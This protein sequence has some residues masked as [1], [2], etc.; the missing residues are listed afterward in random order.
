MCFPDK[1][2]FKNNNTRM[3]YSLLF[4]ATVALG[5]LWLANSHPTQAQ[6]FNPAP[7]SRR[8]MI[9][10]GCIAQLERFESIPG[11]RYLDFSGK[12][13]DPVAFLARNGF[14]AGR[15]GDY[16]IYSL[17][18]P[19]PDNSGD[20]NN[21]ERNFRLDK[22][23]L[24]RQVRTAKRLQA[25]GQKVVLTLHFGAD[26]PVDNW[27][28]YVPDAWKDLTYA[29]VC[30]EIEKKTRIYLGAFLDAGIQPDII[31]VGNESNSGMVY[32]YLG[33]DGKMHIRDT[34]T[35][36]N[37]STAGGD[38]RNYPKFA[39]FFKAAILSAKATLRKRRLPVEKTLFSVHAASDPGVIAWMFGNVFGSDE[40]ALGHKRAD[41]DQYF[42]YGDRRGPLMTS[43]PAHIRNVNLR[44]V[45]DI[46]GGSFYPHHPESETQAAYDKAMTP[47]TRQLDAIRARL[48][49]YGKY[50]SGP[51]AGQWKKRFL[52]V[53]FGTDTDE[54]FS[55]ASAKRQS[56]F[57]THFW[58]S[59]AKYPWTVGAMWWE[60]TYCN[61]NWFA[62][63]GSLYRRDPDFVPKSVTD[64][65][66]ECR[67]LSGLATWGKFGARPK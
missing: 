8:F 30:S 20:V 46:M 21:R 15:V 67:P 29:E 24:D 45:V 39:G 35:H 51:Y 14:N 65:V 61:N 41:R 60:P 7:T 31:V 32:Q 66:G 2:M 57:L 17:K 34:K 27:H 54:Y 63:K 56:R 1:R 48:E 49:S 38:I 59:L 47:L 5:A 52:V 37:D 10:G 13:T 40:E 18:A 11:R 9:A 50:T 58:N 22:D 42:Y 12:P 23:G 4:A 53:E 25:T 6:D 62:D 44:D 64:T 33:R 26:G 36:P 28:E 43:I 3:K 55:P 19:R 16:F